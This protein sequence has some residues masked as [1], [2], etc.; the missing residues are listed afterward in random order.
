MIAT[1]KVHHS[2]SKRKG[3]YMRKSMVVLFAAFLCLATLGCQKKEGP[4][5]QAGKKIDKAVESLDTK[6]GDASKQAEKKID[7]ASDRVKKTMESVDD[8]IKKVTGTTA[9]EQEESEKKEKD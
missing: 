5:E 9:R 8:K 7:E 2:P 3:E 1:S 6:I 4:A